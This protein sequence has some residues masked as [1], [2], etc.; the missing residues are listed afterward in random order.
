M[1]FF[2]RFVKFAHTI[3]W[4]FLQ[5]FL[6]G[7]FYVFREL[8]CL[9]QHILATV[10]PKIHL[11]TKFEIL[12]FGWTKCPKTEP[13]FFEIAL[14]LPSFRTGQA[15]VLAKL[16]KKIWFPANGSLGHNLV[17]L[18]KFQDPQNVLATHEQDNCATVS[19][20]PFCDLPIK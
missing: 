19:S 12:P 2:C 8:F 15:S 10:Q 18:V 1:S 7:H 20:T 13:F 4:A 3:Q 6:F 17:T 16:T 11:N 5:K 9:L 14:L